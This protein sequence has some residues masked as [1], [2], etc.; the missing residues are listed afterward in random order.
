VVLDCVNVV[1]TPTGAAA[2]VVGDV[3]HSSGFAPAAGSRA[4]FLV[5]DNT[6]AGLPDG[7]G[8]LGP[9]VPI[10][11]NEIQPFGLFTNVSSGNI[12]IR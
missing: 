6:P 8:I 9:E 4:G 7:V 5:W 3:I 1:A 12:V 2:V 10:D 11:C